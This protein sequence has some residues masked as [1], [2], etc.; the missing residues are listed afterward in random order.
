M[1]TVTKSAEKETYEGWDIAGRIG[2]L[3][4]SLATVPWLYA[5]VENADLVKLEFDGFKLRRAMWLVPLYYAV[6][7]AGVGLFFPGQ[8]EYVPVFQLAVV[9][10]LAGLD[11]VT[12]TVST[13]RVGGFV[14]V[15]V[16]A[17]AVGWT[18][19]R[20]TSYR[21][22]R[23]AARDSLVVPL[24]GVRDVHGEMD[25]SRLVELDRDL[26]V[27]VLGQTG[28]GKT[29]TIKLLAHQM[30]AAED[31]AFVVFDYKSDYR[32]FFDDEEL[33]RLSIEGSTHHWNV[34]REAE[35]EDDYDEIARAL[36]AG[37]DREN[38][39]EFFENAAQ[40]VFAGVLKFLD[41]EAEARGDRPTNRDL[42]TFFRQTGAEEIE[43]ALASHD[44][45]KGLTAYVSSDASKQ[46]VG[47][48]A[49]IQKTVNEV[50]TGDFA[51][52]G[53]FSVREY[54]RNPDG[55]VL[56]LDF[57]ITRGESV[58]PAFRLF[59]DWSIRFGLDEGDSQ[60]YYLLDE[61][62]R[63]PDLERIDDLVNVGR[64]QRAIGILGLQSV[65]QLRD[66][67]GE[68]KAD[69]LLSGLAQE[70]LMR[71]G[72]RASIQ[73][74]REQLGKEQYER[75]QVDYDRENDPLKVQ[76]QVE[77]R[78]PVAEREIEELDTGEALI[79]TGEGW[80]RGS[81]HLLSEVRDRLDRT[82]GD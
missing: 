74:V 22:F 30:S 15:L 5:V 78:Y 72:D 23:E 79:V 3:F 48:V 64:A 54:V 10:H 45:L 7:A 51:E 77:E 59:V 41:R 76:S 49:T 29:E 70:V 4:A 33:V 8:W 39:D 40:Q 69:A 34:F 36:F 71:C 42:V 35:S 56:V 14:G 55:R 24:R 13:L 38:A 80:I 1:I 65:A 58:K 46:A 16:G 9:A 66:T 31:E 28:A 73:Y 6:S 47:V 25:H 26:S 12:A 20:R 11:A 60:T 2:L 21:R 68:E 52:D 44:D 27:L 17:L 62:Q 75:E 43:A 37:V 32:E 61:F 18:A 57:P 53:E 67:Y 63:I 50:F 19:E 81:I 82:T